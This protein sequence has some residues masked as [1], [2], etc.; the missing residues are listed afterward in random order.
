MIIGKCVNCSQVYAEI[1]KA[2]IQ[3]YEC[4]TT[5][6]LNQVPQ[7]PRVP[8]S[9][10]HHHYEQLELPNVPLFYRGECQTDWEVAAAEAPLPQPFSSYPTCP[11][12]QTEVKGRGG[13]RLLC[14][15]TVG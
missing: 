8:Q 7:Y 6:V 15:V 10:H 11:L 3:D 4:F 13:G 9:W 14:L 2:Y 1:S 5:V 12:L